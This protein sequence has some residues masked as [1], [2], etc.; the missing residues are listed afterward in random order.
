ME[1]AIQQDKHGVVGD[2]MLKS[3]LEKDYHYS[4]TTLALLQ[5]M[6]IDETFGEG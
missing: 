4:S 5:S 3:L 2:N 6:G 1:S